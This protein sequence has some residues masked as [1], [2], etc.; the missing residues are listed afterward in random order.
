MY[1]ATR[2]PQP[3]ARRSCTS[4]SPSP[5]PYY[6]RAPIQGSLTSTLTPTSMKLKNEYSFGFLTDG[7]TVPSPS[8]FPTLTNIYHTANKP[9]WLPVV[10]RL[11]LGMHAVQ[12][13]FGRGPS[14]NT[15][16]GPFHTAG[17]T[18]PSG[19]RR[20]KPKA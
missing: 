5:I 13:S 4:S 3:M 19:S 17:R 18:L 11:G 12:P 2:D 8:P 14:K 1:G 6:Y 16:G 20:P 7:V 15:Y 10:L 9:T